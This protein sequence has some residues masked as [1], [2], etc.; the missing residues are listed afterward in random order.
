MIPYDKR[1]FR[2]TADDPRG[3][4]VKVQLPVAAVKRLIGTTG[5]LPVP[6]EKLN[7]MELED[8]MRT[9]EQCLEAETEGDIITIDAVDGTRDDRKRCHTGGGFA[10]GRTSRQ[11][12]IKQLLFPQGGESQICGDIVWRRQYVWSS[13]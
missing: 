12:Y 3:D 7:G 5:K 4:K 13:P 8:L 11:Q 2:I 1:M 9:V 6:R 10:A